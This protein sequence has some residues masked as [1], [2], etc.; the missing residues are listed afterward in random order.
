MSS[1]GVL[2]KKQIADVQAQLEVE[3]AKNANVS[4]G[5]PPIDIGK[6]ETIVE[7]RTPPKR[8]LRNVNR[9]GLL[10]ENCNTKTS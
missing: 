7:R 2:L 1:K 9:P 4:D 10:K 5:T 8:S 6:K 3:M